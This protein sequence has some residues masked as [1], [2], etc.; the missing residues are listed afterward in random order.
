MI[1]EIQEYP[2]RL[3]QYVQI[4]IRDKTRNKNL[5]FHVMVQLT[6]PYVFGNQR[7]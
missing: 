2:A 6:Y 3:W 7:N 4:F 5:S 1:L